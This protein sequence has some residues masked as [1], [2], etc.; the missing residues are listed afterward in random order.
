MSWCACTASPILDS[1]PLGHPQTRNG[2]WSS[3][4]SQTRIMEMAVRN[5]WTLISCFVSLVYIPWNAMLCKVCWLLG[6]FSRI[7]TYRN[8]LKQYYG[9]LNRASNS[10][11]AIS[12]KNITLLKSLNIWCIR[13][14]TSRAAAFLLIK[15]NHFC[16][17]KKDSVQETV[18]KCFDAKF[19]R[20]LS[21]YF[22]NF[23]RE[24]ELELGRLFL[25][26]VNFPQ[27]RVSLVL[28]SLEKWNYK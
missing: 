28:P 1:S 17:K 10:E 25:S 6:V 20:K 23:P 26:F 15:N 5:L 24:V 2:S 27:G 21:H 4:A 18:F 8:V 11:D 22:C 9:H 7:Y 19:V 16:K 13:L 3:N 12:Y 14:L